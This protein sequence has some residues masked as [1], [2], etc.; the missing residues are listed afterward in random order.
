LCKLMWTMIHCLPVCRLEVVG[1]APGTS[2]GQGGG[3][4]AGRLKGQHP[5]LVWSLYSLQGRQGLGVVRPCWLHRWVGSIM[6]CSNMR[7]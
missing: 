4:L 5:H 6:M 1:V 7:A 2:T 3:L